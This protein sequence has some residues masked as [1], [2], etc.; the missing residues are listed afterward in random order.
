MN[1]STSAVQ[2]PS[3]I[4]VPRPPV[5]RWPVPWD[6]WRRAWMQRR[7][8]DGGAH[9]A[10]RGWWNRSS[11]G[12]KGAGALDQDEVDHDDHDRDEG[13]RGRVGQVVGDALVDVDDVA[14]ELLAAAHQVGD[15]V[16]PQ[17]QREGE[18]RAG[19]DAG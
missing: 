3:P 15:D 14:D 8:G 19:R 1:S 2:M 18:D 6:S 16:V 12:I 9:R 13:E 10:A 17:R 11:Q 7:P 4:R 5:T